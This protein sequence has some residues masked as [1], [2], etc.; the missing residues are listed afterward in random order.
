MTVRPGETIVNV[1]AQKR[2][3]VLLLS[4]G[5]LSAQDAWARDECPVSEEVLLTC[6]IG[7]KT[8]S[9]CKSAADKIHYRFGERGRAPD[10]V[11][12]ADS[13]KPAEAFFWD[14][15]SYAKGSAQYVTFSNGYYIYI[16]YTVRKAFSTVEGD[17]G[18]G[19]FVMR[20]GLLTANLRCTEQRPPQ[21]LHETFSALSIGRSPFGR[22]PN[23]QDEPLRLPLFEGE[24]EATMCPQ[25]IG[26]TPEQCSHFAISLFEKQS[27]LCGVHSFAA[28]GAGRVD[29]GKAPSIVGRFAANKAEIVVTSGRVPTSLRV[30]LVRSTDG[31]VDYIHWK[32]LDP[33]TISDS[34]LPINVSLTRPTTPVFAPEHASS[35]REVCGFSASH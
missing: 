14:S 25:G 5:A 9:L 1:N 17:T 19:V 21:R 31:Y 8:M 10:L 15:E 3:L 11:Y 27:Q 16:V 13:R 18:T 35:A 34:L 32:A 22:P 12:P 23:P 28:P 29:E 6:T 4:W 2:F 24:W 20:D 30:S 26:I 7:G 33:N